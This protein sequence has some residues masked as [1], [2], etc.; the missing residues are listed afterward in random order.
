MGKRADALGDF[1]AL[2][3]AA[4]IRVGAQANGVAVYEEIEGRTGR[5]P[6]VPAVHVT[7]RRL[8]VKGLLTSEVGTS[9]PRGGRPRRY[10]RPTPAGVARLT[11]F[12][13][14]WRRV[15]AGLQLPDVEGSS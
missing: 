1:E 14:T 9:S 2:V 6:S 11:D 5:D 13:D 3:L 12:R 10:Y 7:L 4:V 15:W 8:E